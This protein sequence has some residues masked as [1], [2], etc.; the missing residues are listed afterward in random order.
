MGRSSPFALLDHHRDPHVLG[1][2]P[3]PGRAVRASAWR[4]GPIPGR[5]GPTRLYGRRASRGRSRN[6]GCQLAMDL[7]L[8][9]GY[10]V[11]RGVSHRGSLLFLGVG[12]PSAMRPENARSG[13]QRL[14]ET[15]RAQGRCPCPRRLSAPRRD[16]CPRH[17][18]CR[19]VPVAGVG[20]TLVGRT[21]S[22]AIGTGPP[23]RPSRWSPSSRQEGGWCACPLDG[24]MA[25]SSLNPACRNVPVPGVEVSSIGITEH[26]VDH[27]VSGR[28]DDRPRRRRPGSISVRL[29]ARATSRHQLRI[30]QKAFPTC[31]VARRAWRLCS[32]RKVIRFTSSRQVD[33]HRCTSPARRSPSAGRCPRWPA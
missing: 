31:A 9:G 28:P 23:L 20:F 25:H 12:Q 10:Q 8:G 24:W 22:A 16:R 14:T 4:D 2:D 7:L 32:S 26:W 1:L 17:R 18:R 30:R 19:A 3:A 21:L 27:A 33:H 29:L 11:A 15:P 5:S 6:R 13:G